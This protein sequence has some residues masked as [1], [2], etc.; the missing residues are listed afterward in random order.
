M[1]ERPQLIERLFDTREINGK[2][3]YGVWINVNGMWE[4]V[5]LDDN[6]PIDSSGNFAMSSSGQKEI[7]V[8]L[9]EKAYAKCYGNY[10]VISGGDPVLAM[11]DL[12]GAPF[13][14]IER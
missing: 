3:V 14:R 9:L 5:V 1:A 7:W 2:G 6:F 4:Q 11:R 8:S 13:Q 10:N 12:T